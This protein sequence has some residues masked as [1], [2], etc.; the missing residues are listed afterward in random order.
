MMQAVFEQN[1]FPALANAEFI[2]LTTYRRNGVP[3]ETPVL[4]AQDDDRVYV[5]ACNEAGKVARLQATGRA[6][7]APCTPTGRLL[8]QKMPVQG[9]VL[10]PE[11]AGPVASQ[12]WT[13][14]P[15]LRRALGQ[16]GSS[17]VDPGPRV[18]LELRPYA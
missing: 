16:V 10:A 5:V 17:D 4:F 9:R 15:T 3:V 18:L 8:G 2:S 7:I 1:A 13:R 12:L 14:Y 6:T 11:E